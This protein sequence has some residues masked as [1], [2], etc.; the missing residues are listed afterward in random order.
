[1][2]KPELVA[3]GVDIVAARA[4]GTNLQDPIDEYY[5]AISGTSMASPHVAGAAALLAQRHPDWTGEQLKAALVGAADPL[6]GVDP[7]AVG[8]GRLNAARALG[9]PIS[10]QPVVNLGTFAYPQS[11]TSET[12]LS[13]T[14][15][16]TPA[17]VASRPRR[18][19]RQP[20][21]PAGA[22]RRGV[23]LDEP[24][25]AQ[26]RRPPPA[27]RCGS[28][29]RR[30][31][32]GRASTW[33][34]SPPALPAASWSSTTPVSFYVEPPSYDLTIQTEA[35]AGPAGRRGEL[36]QPAGHQPR[37]PDDLLRRRG[38]SRPETPSRCGSRPA[39]TRSLGA[40]VAYYV[41]SDVLETTLAAE[42]D[43]DVRGARSVTLD[44]ARAKPVTATV[45][46]VPTKPTTDRPHQRPDRAERAVLVAP[47]QRVGASRRRSA[48]PRCRSPPSGPGARGRPVNL[49]SPAGTAKPYRYDLVHEYA[50]RRPGRPRLPG[51]KAE[52]AKL[53][54]ID[55]R[56][57]Q[58]DSPGMVTSTAPHGYTPDG[59][60]ADPDRTTGPAGDPHRLPLARVPLGGRGNLRRPARPRRRPAATS[61][62]AGRPRSGRGSRCTPAGTTTRPAPSTS[63]ATAPSR[64]RGNLHI[65]LVMLTDQHQRAD[66]LAGRHDRREPQAVALPRRQ[67]GRASGSRPLA[68]FTV[69]QKAADYRLTFDVDTSLILPISTQVNTSWTFRSAGPDGTASVPLPLLVGRLRAA[70]GRGQPPH[71]WHGRLRP[72]GRRRASRRSR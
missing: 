16:P 54:R 43:L 25:D 36:G 9:G 33:P 71:R 61:R 66:C 56:F 51:D 27:R 68:D 8:A 72:S 29:A 52:Q 6:T 15:E 32:P 44:P 17:T 35:A 64:T 12:K 30:W 53:A 28:T 7:Y 1:M 55:E 42:A 65:D 24:G 63:C 59:V 26:A 22:A 13:W 37:R 70:A 18:V 40:S 14:G 67:A 69:P 34:P 10:D 39:G 49:D 47:D 4:A 31:P 38:R 50:Q 48:P 20:R 41:D 11:G 45:D 5:E 57:H 60:L 21:R 23:A 58:M 62:A 3:P 2:A 19:G 46:G